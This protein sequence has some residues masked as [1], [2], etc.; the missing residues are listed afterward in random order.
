G[1][2]KENIQ[3][4]R[5]NEKVI[6]EVV[7][8]KKVV[9]QIGDKT[10]FNVENSVLSKGNNGLEILQKSPKLSINSEGIILLKNKAVTILINGR[11]T[12]LS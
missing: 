9:Q 7:V 2:V 6:Q 5:D 3:L 1:D 4:N 11:K 12:N 10:Y 8:N